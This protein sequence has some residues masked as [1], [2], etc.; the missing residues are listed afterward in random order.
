MFDLCYISC[1]YDKPMNCIVLGNK[2]YNI[3]FK[4]ITI[5]ISTKFCTKNQ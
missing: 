3:F 1:V 4:R 2:Q 5:P